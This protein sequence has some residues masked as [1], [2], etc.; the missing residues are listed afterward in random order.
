MGLVGVS[1][2]SSCD[3]PATPKKKTTTSSSTGSGTGGMGGSASIGINGGTADSLSFAIVGDT[4]PVNYN[5]TTS[6]PTAVIT[7]IW[8]D[9]EAVNPRPPFA[10]GTG[11]YQYSST[12]GNVAGTQMDIYMGARA[13]YSGLFFPAMGNHECTGATASNCGNGNPNGITANYTA[14]MDKMLGPI[15]KTTPYYEIDVNSTKAGAWT[16]KFVFVAAN[17]WTADQSTWLDA[18]LAKSTTYTFVIRHERSDT[19]DA[20]GVAPSSAI[21]AK[22][23]VTMVIVG[24][25]HT[26][27]HYAN[28]KEIIVGNG[29]APLS[30]NVNY[31]Y[32]ITTQRQDGAIDFHAYD[33]LSNGTIDDFAVKADGSPAG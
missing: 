19:T 7:K 20:P 32:V 33:Y 13:N 30:G 25:T 18:A 16:A 3:S 29:G 2:L 9:V 5:A 14:F 24:H 4:R 17:A 31:G 10:I 1:S 27:S 23:P 6:Y 28:T 21:I 12:F 26:Y 22:Y 8:Q 11:D 15:Q